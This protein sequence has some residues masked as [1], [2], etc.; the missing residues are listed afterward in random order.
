MS[1]VLLGIILGK[2]NLKPSNIRECKNAREL[3]RIAKR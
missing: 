3:L 1:F 2:K